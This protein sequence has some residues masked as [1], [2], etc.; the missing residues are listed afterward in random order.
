MVKRDSSLQRKHFPCS[1]VQWW[2]A[3]HPS[4]RRLALRMV[5]LG[6]CAAA[7][8]LKPISWI[9]R[10]RVLV[11]TLLPE[12]VW[13]SVVVSVSTE[14]RRFLS[15]TRFSTQ[16][17]RSVSLCGL[18]LFGRAIVAPRC[19][20]FTITALTVDRGS[21]SMA[22][23]WQTDL[24]ERG[25]LM[26]VPCWNSVRPFYCQCLS[27]EIALLCARFYT[28]VSN[29]C[30]WNSLIRSFERVSIHTFVYIVHLV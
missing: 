14:D 13:N 23:I 28:P 27:M 21:S 19:F 15:A 18:P 24:L 10:Q 8:P 1:R 29:R 3:L 5:T 6:L 7:R 22:E 4:S 16:R 12:A 25:H 20:H 2:W 11:L 26:T 17:S 9:S 30:G